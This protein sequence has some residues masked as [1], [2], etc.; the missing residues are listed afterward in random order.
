MEEHLQEQV[1]P[2][3]CKYIRKIPKMKLASQ[4]KG[5]VVMPI[6][7]QKRRLK[8]QPVTNEIKKFSVYCHL[9]RVRADSQRSS[10]RGTWKISL[11]RRK[12]Q[13]NFS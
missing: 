8:A 4:V 1:Y 10:G 3:P 13:E 2:Y 7:E 9:R 5:A 12:A 6:K 11:T